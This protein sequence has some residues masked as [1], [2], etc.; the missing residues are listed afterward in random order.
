MTGLSA[1]RSSV[2]EQR[3]SLAPD[4]VHLWLCRAAAVND[5]ALREAYPHLLNESERRRC[6]S[7]H[8]QL[9]E[10]ALLTR[11]LVRTV[12]SRYA[13]LAPAA[14]NFESNDNGK[15]RVA[16]DAA[17]GLEFN[18]SHSHGWVVC[19]VSRGMTVGVDVEHC[20]AQRDFM[21]LAQRYFLAA[22]VA[23]LE[24]REG[25]L[26][27]DLFYE[28]W[29]LKEAWSKSRGGNIGSAMGAVGFSLDRPGNID[30]TGAAAE[31]PTDCWLLAPEPGFRLALCRGQQPSGQAKL[32]VFES[33]PLRESRT[34]ELPAL[35]V[36]S[37]F[38]GAM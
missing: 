36:S 11:V 8:E 20:D 15:P 17:P 28:L 23:A 6:A 4:A 25:E 2:S 18:L 14:W 12:L 13:P 35:A 5:P 3:L 10:E 34:V 7:L 19:A 38:A 33:V 32:Q 21:R 37:G 22:E 29:T 24:S 31:Y 9:R 1:S 16:G 26:Q 30:I 27:R